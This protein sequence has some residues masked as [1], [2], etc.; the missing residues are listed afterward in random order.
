MKFSCVGGV[1]VSYD[2]FPLD[3]AESDVVLCYCG[4][5]IVTRSAAFC[6]AHRNQE[7]T[8]SIKLFAD[9]LFTSIGI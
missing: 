5:L 3:F 6:T 4:T 2:A 9:L 1:C 7:M 8:V